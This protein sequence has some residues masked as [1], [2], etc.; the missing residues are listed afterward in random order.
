MAPLHQTVGEGVD[1]G[2]YVSKDWKDM[3]APSA[4]AGVGGS[5]ALGGSKGI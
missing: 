2:G 4:G 1:G 3:R 5:S